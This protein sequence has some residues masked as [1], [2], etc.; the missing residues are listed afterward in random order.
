M[1]HKWRRKNQRRK[2]R[3]WT[4]PQKKGPALSQRLSDDQTKMWEIAA[5]WDP[6]G[7]SRSK[8]SRARRMLRVRRGWPRSS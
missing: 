5:L 2:Q 8:G 1:G 4:V 7:L 3:V 6:L